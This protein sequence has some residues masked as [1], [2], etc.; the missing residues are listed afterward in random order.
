[1]ITFRRLR[2]ADFPQLSD[3]LRRPHVA[4]WWREPHDL[5]SI[6]ARYGPS[7]DGDDPTEV[8]VAVID[9]HDLGLVQW[10][11]LADNLEWRRSLAGAHVDDD[12]AGLD[13]FIADERHVGRGLGP[14]MLTAFLDEVLPRHPQVSSLVLSVS[15]DNVRSWRMLEALGFRRAWEGDIV[16][17]DPSDE[18][19]SYVY[20]RHVG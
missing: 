7:V 10:Y 17:S 3:W 14:R 1:M 4:R 5:A 13:Y 16:S 8:V 19:P 9:G 15:Q 6:E 18:G 2:R 20:V 11:L 12:A